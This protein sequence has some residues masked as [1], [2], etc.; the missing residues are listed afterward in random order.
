LVKYL[1]DQFGGSLAAMRAGVYPPLSEED[2]MPT[3]SAGLPPDD[4]RHTIHLDEGEEWLRHTLDELRTLRS[5]LTP[6]KRAGARRVAPEQVAEPASHGF[7]FW[8][9]IAGAVASIIGLIIV[10]VLIFFG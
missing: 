1:R 10:V 2:G 9:G 4:G 6:A 5:T 3:L 8:L 7:L